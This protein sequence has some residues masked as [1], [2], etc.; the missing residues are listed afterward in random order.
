MNH[1]V[2]IVTYVHNP[3][4]KKSERHLCKLPKFLIT[5]FAINVVT[6]S[7]LLSTEVLFRTPHEQ[8]KDIVILCWRTRLIRHENGT[9]YYNSYSFDLT[10]LHNY[11]HWDNY[12]YEHGW[13]FLYISFH[14]H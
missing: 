10:T 7:I 5:D 2:N 3:F 4:L 13:C 12:M 9:L 11:K 14:S 1:S 6:I 8:I